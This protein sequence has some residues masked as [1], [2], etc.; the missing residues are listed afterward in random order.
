MEPGPES[1]TIYQTEIQ[2]YRDLKAGTA[3]AAPASWDIKRVRIGEGFNELDRAGYTVVGSVLGSKGKASIKPCRIWA[4]PTGAGRASAI[5]IKSS[6]AGP[7]LRGHSLR[8]P[9]QPRRLHGA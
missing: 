5:R 7:A 9:A 2:L 3:P 8:Q 1:I 4:K 6:T